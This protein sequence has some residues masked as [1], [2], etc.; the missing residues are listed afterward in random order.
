[1]S[2]K[3]IMIPVP[4]PGDEWQYD[5]IRQ[6][7]P[8]EKHYVDGKWRVRE[9]RKPTI[10]KYLVARR[11]P[12]PQPEPSL[13]LLLPY[14]GRGYYDTPDGEDRCHWVT[15]WGG[16]IEYRGAIYQM[17]FEG[18]GNRPDGP[19]HTYPVFQGADGEARFYN[20]ARFVRVDG[21]ESDAD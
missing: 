20:Y 21:S 15:L 7:K 2:D 19:W 11:K 4:D 6:A 9:G 14:A 17:A 3:T 5:G 8:G 1:M 10:G 18:Y 16:R 12:E 13:E